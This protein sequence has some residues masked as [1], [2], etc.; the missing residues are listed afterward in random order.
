MSNLSKLSQLETLLAF[1]IK[2]RDLGLGEH[3]MARYSKSHTTACQH[4]TVCLHARETLFHLASNDCKGNFSGSCSLDCASKKLFLQCFRSHPTE[5]TR[6]SCK[7]CSET[8]PQSVQ[9]LSDTIEKLKRT[10]IE[11]I[12]TFQHIGASI[13]TPKSH[14]SGSLL[15]AALEAIPIGTGAVEVR[16]PQQRYG[17]TFSQLRV[18]SLLEA[19]PLFTNP[20]VSGQ[21]HSRAADRVRAEIVALEQAAKSR[22]EASKRASEVTR[23]EIM[24]TIGSTEIERIE[25]EINRLAGLFA[26]A[27]HRA[28]SSATESVALSKKSTTHSIEGSKS[29]DEILAVF[30]IANEE[31][32]AHEAD[33]KSLKDI[34]VARSE[35]DKERFKNYN[36]SW[37]DAGVCSTTGAGLAHI[38]RAAAHTSGA[39]L[40]QGDSLGS[41]D[42]YTCLPSGP[43][44]LSTKWLTD[45]G[46][47]LPTTLDGVPSSFT[48]ALARG[49]SVLIESV[50]DIS[51]STISNDGT[52]FSLS[53]HPE[54]L[55]PK[56]RLRSSHLSQGIQQKGRAAQAV[57]D[58][59]VAAAASPVSYVYDVVTQMLLHILPGILAVTRARNIKETTAARKLHVALTKESEATI[60]RLVPG[61]IA[62]I[63]APLEKAPGA[64]FEGGG[65][66]QPPIEVRESNDS[67]IHSLFQAIRGEWR[68][69]FQTQR[70]L[71][72]Q[73]TKSGDLNRS[74]KTAY[75][76]NLSADQSRPDRAMPSTR[77]ADFIKDGQIPPSALYI[78]M[79]REASHD[80]CRKFYC[81][82]LEKMA[83]QLAL[84]PDADLQEFSPETFPK[85]SKEESYPAVPQH[86]SYQLKRTIALRSC[87]GDAPPLVSGSNL[88]PDATLVQSAI[89]NARITPLDVLTFIK[90]QLSGTYNPAT[91]APLE[92][93]SKKKSVSFS[94]AAGLLNEEDEEEFDDE[95]QIK[96]KARHEMLAEMRALGKELIRFEAV[97]NIQNVN[98]NENQQDIDQAAMDQIEKTSDVF[99]VVD[100]T[101]KKTVSTTKTDSAVK[102]RSSS[103]ASKRTKL[104]TT[105]AVEQTVG[106][107]VED[108]FVEEEDETAD[109]NNDQIDESIDRIGSKRARNQKR[110]TTVLKSIVTAA[111]IS[112]KTTSAVVSATVKYGKQGSKRPLATLPLPPTKVYTID[113]LNDKIRLL[114]S[115]APTRLA[116]HPRPARVLRRVLETFD[117]VINDKGDEN[118][119]LRAVAVIR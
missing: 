19:E 35:H 105:A 111:T 64:Q 70:S 14:N 72:I 99:V 50:D 2:C 79:I 66:P 114:Q 91:L 13:Q 65:G 102:N 18:L 47:R 103:R 107:M 93:S 89:S 80:A 36:R 104:D 85:D 118:L 28:I 67:N 34:I 33:I 94:D 55:K 76:A 57:H 88:G 25:S 45:L 24:A 100:S 81:R 77:D 38:L 26:Q 90:S 31:A 96:R 68:Q 12:G 20:A 40:F 44:F 75:L 110:N 29:I 63:D 5:A 113:E 46:A 27:E 60:A 8:T 43:S 39:L 87:A 15:V 6:L 109:A 92:S 108:A 116:D 115:V 54:L 82:P 73:K 56:Y 41:I 3:C 98:E 84:R 52:P 48:S 119:A 117:K 1:S 86:V 49:E 69:W 101:T 9:A 23:G 58:A 78:R 112:S 16:R 4:G 61:T 97:P 10:E 74:N 83:D 30:R 42:T 37:R 53:A 7:K 106:E 59:A 95:D 32:K 71:V 11:P 17:P 51:S 62:S 21:L 22:S